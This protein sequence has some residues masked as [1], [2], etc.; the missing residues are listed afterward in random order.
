MI[1]EIRKFEGIMTLR[2]AQITG[3]DKTIIQADLSTVEA[4]RQDEQAK[5]TVA[6]TYVAMG[7]PLSQVV[8]ALDLPFQIEDK[9]PEQSEGAPDAD[10]QGNEA[11]GGQKSKGFKGDTPKDIAWKKYDRDIAPIEQSLQSSLRAYFR[12]QGNRVMAAFEQVA[13]HIVPDNGKAIKSIDDSVNSFFNFDKEKDLFGRTVDPKIRKAYYDFAVRMAN[14]IR[15]GANF[16][17]DESKA[18]VWI[19]KKVLK[20]QQ[21][22]TVYTREQLTDA[23]VESVR[24]AVGAGLSQSETIDQIRER[25]NET[26]EFAATSRAERI[27]RTEVI[28]ASNAGGEQAMKDLGAI[29]KEW[30]TSRDDRVRDTHAQMDGQVVDINQPFISSDGESLMY[31]GDQSAGPGA[32]INCRCTLT[33]IMEK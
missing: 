18:G 17:V 21:E 13:P 2:A 4:L 20:L 10:E 26:Y 1:P 30:L 25:I 24:D 32:V 11:D 16:S 31:P 14:G 22:V 5:A 15:G 27:A 6:Q 28:G 23:I 8:E 9:Q 3:D 19:T 29:G 7:I 12:A 33:P